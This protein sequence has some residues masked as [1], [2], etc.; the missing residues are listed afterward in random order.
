MIK[1]DDKVDD[2]NE[3]NWCAVELQYKSADKDLKSTGL[4]TRINLNSREQ[5]LNCCLP[6][7]G[8]DL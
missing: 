8:L 5:F 3:M 7:G 1:S 4:F 6:S 2:K